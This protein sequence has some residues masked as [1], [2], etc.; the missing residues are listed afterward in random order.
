MVSELTKAKYVTPAFA[1]KRRYK[2]ISRRNSRSP[3]YA[4]LNHFTLLLCRGRQR[5]EQRFIT[6]ASKQ[7]LFCS[8]NINFLFGG[9]LVVVAVV[10]GLLK[11]SKQ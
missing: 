2:K 6:D 5:N 3:R 11:L 1:S 9:V 8:L 4:E 10:R 7:L